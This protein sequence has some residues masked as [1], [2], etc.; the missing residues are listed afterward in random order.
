MKFSRRTISTIFSKSTFTLA[1][2]GGVVFLSQPF[3]SQQNL[4]SA[5]SLSITP[6]KATIQD[7]APKAGFADLIERIS[8]AVV[9]VA[10]SG[11]PKSRG[12]QNFNF[13]PVRDD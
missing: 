1:L 13:P 3:V 6:V 8:P 2:I 11:V 10:I 12:A 5:K 7:F 9:H 4:A